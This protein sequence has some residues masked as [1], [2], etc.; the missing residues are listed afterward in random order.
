MRLEV[1]VLIV[2]AGPVGLASALALAHHGVRS[3][4]VEKH[5]GTSIFPK[6][7]GINVRTMELL[8]QWGLNAQVLETCLQG[9]GH[10]YVYIGRTLHD[11][12]AK[13]ITV[14]DRGAQTHSPEHTQVGS[15]VTLEKILLEAVRA[16]GLCDLRF[17]TRLTKFSQNDQTVTATLETG[18]ETLE[19]QAQYM[20]AA[21]GGKSD[22]RERLGIA[23]EGEDNLGENLNVLLEADLEEHTQARPCRFFMLMR[24]PHE[25][26]PGMA[27]G[28]RILFGTSG[29]PHR[30]QFGVVPAPGSPLPEASPELVDAW[31]TSIVGQPVP[32]RILGVQPW[33]AKGQLAS[34]FR[35]R[36]IFLAGDAAHVTTPVGGFGM[37]TGIADAHNLAWKLAGVLQGWAH[38]SLLETYEN[39]RRPVGEFTVNMS[40]ARLKELATPRPPSGTVNEVS[41]G[42]E[43]GYTYTSSAVIPDGTSPPEVNDPIA[44]YVPVAR[45]GHRAPHVWLEQNRSTLDLF[46]KGL[47]LLTDSDAW[48]EAIKQVETRALIQTQVI[49]N[50]QF[51]DAY[52]LEPGGAVLVRPDGFVAWRTR[53]VLSDPVRALESALQSLLGIATD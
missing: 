50:G 20:I 28:S 46:G 3:M 25:P 41:T 2:G 17:E 11:P 53:E 6:A 19:V 15:Q 51:L 44:E 30:W 29:L 23:F 45:P 4:L 38:E 37:N 40:V 13:H 10:Q 36:R 21:D 39:E 43:L 12:E 14:S 47:T 33:T 49:T 32:H 24:P 9:E 1:P 27:S 42:L 52:G 18:A 31:M 35:E 34:S 5:A 48:L 7:R 16:T 26:F 8:R 22:V